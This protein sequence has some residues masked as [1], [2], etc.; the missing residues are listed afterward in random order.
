MLKQ[1]YKTIIHLVYLERLTINL[2]LSAFQ[3]NASTTHVHKHIDCYATA[4]KPVI[5]RLQSIDHLLK[6]SLITLT[7]IQPKII[8]QLAVFTRKFFTNYV[9]NSK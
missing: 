2:V 5:N 8:L 1:S 4:Q 6:P 3:R 9:T 7:N